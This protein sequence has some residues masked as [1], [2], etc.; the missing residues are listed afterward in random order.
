MSPGGFWIIT[1]IGLALLYGINFLGSYDYLWL[2]VAVTFITIIWAYDLPKVGW[3]LPCPDC[4][5][6]MEGYKTVLGCD[7]PVPGF[8][9]SCDECAEGVTYYHMRD[10]IPLD[11]EF[12]NSF[13]F[14]AN[15]G[16]IA[17][18]ELVRDILT[19]WI[20]EQEQ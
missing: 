12:M 18:D 11:K 15:K 1:Q 13:S 9:F 20:E 17:P 14:H 5:T 10:C 2:F 3:V 4:G 8:H 7:H 6:L 16:M 19:R